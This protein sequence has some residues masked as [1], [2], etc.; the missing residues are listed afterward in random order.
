MSLPPSI[1]YRDVWRILKRARR[2]IVIS[3]LICGCSGLLYSLV[4]PTWHRSCAT[5]REK[6]NSSQKSLMQS[7]GL[8]SSLVAGGASST[9]QQD[10]YSLIRSRKVL[11]PAISITGLQIR[12]R[13]L[14]TPALFLLHLTDHLRLEARYWTDFFDPDTPF[15]PFF[16]QRL[17]A[18]NVHYEGD[19]TL[20]YTLTFLSATSYELHDLS[21]QSLGTGVLGEPFISPLFTLTFSSE[22]SIDY[23][24]MRFRMK[25][26][27]MQK[28]VERCQ[29]HLTIR[30]VKEREKLFQLTF[31]HANRTVV[32][33]FLNTLMLSYQQY[34]I[35]E[36]TRLASK[37]RL[38]LEETQAKALHDLEASIRTYADSSRSLVHTTGFIDPEKQLAFLLAAQQRLSTRQEQLLQEEARCAQVLGLSLHSPMLLLMPSQHMPDEVRGMVQVYLRDDAERKML[39]ETLKGSDLSNNLGNPFDAHIDLPATQAM[40]AY[41]QRREQEIGTLITQYELFLT[42]LND[43]NFPLSSLVEALED[44]ISREMILLARSLQTK[45]HDKDT[46][47]AKDR[48]H[49]EHSLKMQREEAETHFTQRLESLKQQTQTIQRQIHAARMH[50]LT[51]LNEKLALDER[52]IKNALTALLSSFSQEKEQLNREIRTL[53]GSIAEVPALWAMQQM[54]QTSLELQ[55]VALKE[56]SKWMESQ[57]AMRLQDLLASGP[58]DLAIPPLFPSYPGVLLYTLLGLLCGSLPA[59]V[60]ALLRA[61]AHG[62]IVSPE[63]LELMGQKVIGRLESCQDKTRELLR[64]VLCEMLHAGNGARERTLWII[65]LKEGESEHA[66]HTLVTLLEAEGKQV[67]VEKGVNYGN[68]TEE[69]EALIQRLQVAKAASRVDEVG[70]SAPLTL[71]FTHIPASSGRATQLMRHAHGSIVFLA[72]ESVTTAE[73]APLLSTVESIQSTES[74]LFFLFVQADAEVKEKSTFRVWNLWNLLKLAIWAV[75]ARSEKRNAG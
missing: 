40:V 8:L 41:L 42:Q 17:S 12:L 72:E 15:E 57:Q 56:R 47:L 53:Q 10:F 26:V 46:Y 73:L 75:H 14:L 34:H 71:V 67:I 22:P 1:P 45:L 66:A 48:L 5:F 27:S 74:L 3:A 44:P 63:L 39:L 36:T 61:R 2:Y 33:S 4:K 30:S 13:P 21:G 70:D 16:P 7:E 25:L 50:M 20:W 69:P 32:S 23:A 37:E 55:K 38:L 19:S 35:E 6:I 29:S 68:E 28:A 43:L 9:S 31:H 11:E 52:E 65:F 18:S 58:V 49:I 62:L 51:L 64:H 24:G 59:A 54:E 60:Y